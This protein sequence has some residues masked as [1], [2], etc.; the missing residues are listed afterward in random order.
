MVA[1]G[2]EVE[3]RC[4]LLLKQG[5]DLA[6]LVVAGVVPHQNCVRPPVTVLEIQGLDQLCQEELHRLA[7]RV[8]L[9][10]AGVD[11]AL[12]VEGHDQSDSWAD[13][14]ERNTVADPLPMP[15]PPSI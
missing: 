12:A 3:N 8:G 2:A 6:S 4:S 14:L 9:E 7:I 5:E 10:Q 13:F 11:L 15:G 1:V